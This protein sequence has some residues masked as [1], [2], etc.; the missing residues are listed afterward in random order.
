MLAEWEESQSL[1]WHRKTVKAI[2]VDGKKIKAD[3]F[4]ILKNGKFKKV[5]DE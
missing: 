4:Y 5:K 3:T 1:V 2:E